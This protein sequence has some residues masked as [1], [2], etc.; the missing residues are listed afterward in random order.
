MDAGRGFRQEHLNLLLHADGA[1]FLHHSYDSLA[2]AA[3]PPRAM[4]P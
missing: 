4:L 3:A 1:T 2:A